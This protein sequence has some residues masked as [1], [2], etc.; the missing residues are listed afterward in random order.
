MLRHQIEL[1]MAQ[2]MQLKNERT[3]GSHTWYSCGPLS[4][5]PATKSDTPKGLTPLSEKPDSL[6]VNLVRYSMW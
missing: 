2:K 6:E 3:S 5:Y 1:Q 4:S